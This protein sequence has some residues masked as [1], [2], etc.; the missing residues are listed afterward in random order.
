MSLS[1]E[2]SVPQTASYWGVSKETDRRNIRSKRLRA[3]RRGPEWFVIP[4]KLLRFAGSYD[5]RTGKVVQ[6]LSEATSQ[7]QARGELQ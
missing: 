4:R 7:S 1:E 6:S 5:L 3:I 2:L